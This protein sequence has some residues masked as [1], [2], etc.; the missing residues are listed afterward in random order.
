MTTLPLRNAI[1]IDDHTVAGVSGADG[2]GLID[3][4]DPARAPTIVK[5]PGI[6]IGEV[7]A[8][9]AAPN[10]TLIAL[11]FKDGS[12]VVND[13]RARTSQKLNSPGVTERT[14]FLTF[15]SNSKQVFASYQN[16]SGTVFDLASRRVLHHFAQ[17]AISAF[18]HD[19]RLVASGAF[20]GR[21]SISDA[22][23]FHPVGASLSGGSA[24]LSWLQFSAD[25]KW[26][27]AVDSENKLLIFDL[28]TRREIG[29]PIRSATGGNGLIAI[30]N[31]GGAAAITTDQGVQLWS[32]NP[33]DWAKA[34]CASAARNLTKAEWNT[35][36]GG[37]YRVVCSE[38]PVGN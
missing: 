23:S 27:L 24:F 22:H 12:T 19:G 8:G 6:K 15:S 4:R 17:G 7:N 13:V 32:L 10:G 33:K 16:G 18:S 26:L 29:L 38:W 36:V 9:I 28:A 37:P 5:T 11:G 14:N 2:V 34:V 3:L 30:R 35:Y 25:D 20:N 1:P 21:I 31:D